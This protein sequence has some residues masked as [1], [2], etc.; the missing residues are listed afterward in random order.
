MA[1]SASGEAAI[2]DEIVCRGRR[3]AL[4]TLWLPIGDYGTKLCVL[5]GKTTGSYNKTIQYGASRRMI[6]RPINMALKNLFGVGREKAEAAAACGAA[7]GA[8]DQKPAACGTACGAG[9][10]K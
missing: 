9:D 6:R 5:Y 2:A 4:D 1:V 7:C 3:Y 10:Q 8:G